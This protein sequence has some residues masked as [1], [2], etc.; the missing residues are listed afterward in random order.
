MAQVFRWLE[1]YAPSL[2][3]VAIESLTPRAAAFEW[4][5]TTVFGGLYQQVVAVRRA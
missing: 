1:P 2:L 5:K 4:Q 3:E